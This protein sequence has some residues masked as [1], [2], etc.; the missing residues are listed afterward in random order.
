M[1]TLFQFFNKKQ[2]EVYLDTASGTIVSFRTASQF[3]IYLQN[4]SANPHTFHRI[5]K[6][7]NEALRIAR[8]DIATTLGVQSKEIYFTSGGTESDNM[9]IFGAVYAAQKKG[10]AKPHVIIS[11]VEHPA[12]LNSALAL[13]KKGVADVS[14]IPVSREGVIN[15]N[16]I[17]KNINQNTIIVSVMLINNETGARQPV[18]EIAKI[19]RHARKY[20]TKT[21]YPYFH[22]DAVQ[23]YYEG[24]HIP[25][26]GVDMLTLTSGKMYGVRGVG[27]LYKKE[28]VD[29]DPILYGGDQERGLRSGTESVPLVLT[30]RDVLQERKSI[31]EKERA[32]LSFLRE[33]FEG[34]LMKKFDVV[35]HAAHTLRTPHILNIS[36]LGIESEH[37]VLYLAAKGISVSAK[38]ACSSESEEVSHVLQAMYDENI[39]F[40]K[41]EGSIRF[42]FSIDTVKK[43]LEY[44]LEM[45]QGYVAVQSRLK[46]E[47]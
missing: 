31:H 11:A 20:L 38:S 30:F 7:A 47:I 2:K 36:F 19:I 6:N 21:E 37:L 15:L 29:I 28:G 23:G 3:L 42:S 12:I 22:T 8:K 5:G 13:F 34:E 45:I 17:K 43:D 27:L 46:K 33:W 24:L 1:Q 40:S 9:A 39:P 10:I 44:V 16:E 26:L 14:I 25:K 18:E 41:K 4:N 32:R 35:I